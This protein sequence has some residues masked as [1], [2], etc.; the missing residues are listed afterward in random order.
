M[1]RYQKIE[2]VLII[3][4]LL[5]SLPALHAH[6]TH[7]M[8]LEV[9]IEV[10]K[11]QIN[12]IARIG[13]T[14]GKELLLHRGPLEIIQ[15][16]LDEHLINFIEHNGTVKLI[17]EHDGVIEI[18]YKGVFKD[19]QLSH[20]R[21]GKTVQNV[22]DE[23]G[24]SL[25]GRWYPKM[26]GLYYH[27]LKA[28]F[29]KGYEAVSEAEEIRKETKNNTVEFYFH[30]PYPVDNINLVASHRY[31]VNKDHYK[32]IE[33]N[34]YFFQE[35][36][37]LAKTYIGFTKKYLKLYEYL[38]GKYPYK[39]FSVIENFLPTGYS[40]PTFTLLGSTVVRLPFIV[41]TSLGHEILHQWFGNLSYI[42]YEKGNWAE[43]LTTYL[44]DHLYRD[45]KGEGWQYRKQILVDYKSYV[46][47]EGDFPPRYFSGRIDRLS[48]AIGY[49]K[50]AMVFHMIRNILG[51]K[52]FF[53]SL[54]DI[55]KENRFRRTSWDDIKKS[56][57]RVYGQDLKWFFAQWIDREG[58]PELELYG[59]EIRQIGSE[60]ELHFHV[61]QKK[62]FYKLNLPITIYVKEKAIFDVLSIHNDKNSFE[63]M[64]PD[65]PEK[66][67]LDE[68]YDIARELTEDE[69]PP[70]I[71]RIIGDVNLI[72]A[73]PRTREET[74]RSIIDE[75]E[76]KGAELKSAKD[77]TKS[78][79]ESYSVL[80]LGFDNPLIGR[81]YGRLPPE[82]AGFC[83]VVKENPWNSQRVIGIFHGKSK[84]EVDIAFKK[85]PHYGK[86]SKLIFDKGKNTHREI[87]Q[88]EKGITMELNEEAAAID[89][90]KIKTLSDVINGVADKKVIYVGEIHDVFA[91]HA[92][93]LDIITGMYEKNK[94]TAIGMEMFQRPFQET[95]NSFIAGRVGENDFLKRSEY[96]Q[97]WGFDY[98]LYKPILDFA[99]TEN[100]PVVALNIRRE[101]IDKVSKNGIDS[102]SEVEKEA[103]PSEID[104][105]D[106]EYRERL[107]KVF[108]MHK[109]AKDRSFDY[110]YQSQILWD[111]T[112]SQSI[113]EFFRERSDY[114]MIVLAG[115]GHLEYGAGIPKRTFR[116]NGQ[117]YAI[118]L[119]DAKVEKGIADYV[120]FPKP[121]EGITT[122][123][124]MTF[125]KEEKG[126]LKIAGFPEE[127][128]SEEA[129]LK[130]GDIILFIDE[131][132]M[133]NIEDIKIHLLYKRKGDIIEVRILRK[134]KETEKEMEFKVEL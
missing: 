126:R 64:L 36:L 59:I 1:N 133:R 54:K 62:N 108:K 32:D 43:G 94:K 25:T 61:D 27:D 7:K 82:D 44:A 119:I 2:T 14:S 71:A 120:I 66:I 131:V 39:R 111:E 116:R 28:I 72:V 30:F 98:H 15:I 17:P 37:H 33:I 13:V 42:D 115:K 58:L 107:K 8:S 24:V 79:I 102:L 26:D 34:T 103:I 50:V 74:Y 85:I 123:K 124:L 75:F 109:N 84:R 92:V 45:Q 31:K 49:G 19:S 88:T 46:T 130:V 87:E 73:L 56:F 52:V 6:A 16:K 53:E 11:S 81:L 101:I 86:Y 40:M 114:Q 23:R 129:G 10:S 35:D 9:D 22:I 67:V 132:E 90:S 96:F 63:F 60:F 106:N 70:V 4:I 80:I 38:I 47:V 55:L 113:D 20:D 83:I 125:L 29:P 105:S 122:P 118:V 76:K 21:N 134:E 41:E 68:D 95:L 18:N 128:V 112:M 48:R 12:G 77:I 117:D 3:I 51:K 100:V 65:R 99:R 91:H 57:E 121:V 89:V 104:L 127:S 97:R 110:F 5:F 93:Q 69:F 78:D